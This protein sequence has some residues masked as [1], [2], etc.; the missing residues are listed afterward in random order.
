VE[1]AIKVAGMNPVGAKATDLKL[2]DLSGNAVSLY[3][4]QAA[5]TVLYF[6]NPECGACAEITPKV[7]EVYQSYK[8]KG[9]Q[10]FA[11]YVDRARDVWMKYVAENKYLDWMNVW[12]ADE[13]ADI[14]G[15][16]DLHVIPM[17]YLLDKDKVVI[18]KDLPSHDLELWLSQLTASE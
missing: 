8:N 14:Y 7:H 9:V 2:A 10:V 5:Y 18:E 16:Y 15:K 6:Y 11:V 13:T 1:Q 4:V 17:I 12:D 3:D